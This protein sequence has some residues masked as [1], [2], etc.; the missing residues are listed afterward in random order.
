M[1]R[2]AICGKMAA[3][4]GKRDALASVMKEAF[5]RVSKLPGCLLYLIFEDL[6]DKD[7]L[8]ITEIWTSKDAHEA[9]LKDASVLATIAKA[10]PLLD[11]PRMTQAKL[12]PLFGVGIPE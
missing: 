7:C 1:S 5:A 10:R 8:W 4:P 9:S 12:N 6:E 2:F 3:Q 11:F